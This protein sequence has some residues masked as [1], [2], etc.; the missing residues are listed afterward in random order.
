MKIYAI[1]GLGAD[2]R[3][4]G[5]LSLNKQFIHLDRVK[6][7]KNESIEKCSFR[8]SKEI[9]SSESF[10]IIG[11]SF[12]GL[13]A[14]EISKILKPKLTILISSAANTQEIPIHYRLLGKFKLVE[15]IPEKIFNKPNFFLNYLFG[16]KYRSL[17]SNIIKDTDVQFAK[18]AVS[19][20]LNWQNTTIIENLIKING[21]KDRLIPVN[22]NDIVIKNGSHFMIL[23]KAKEVS[24]ILNKALLNIK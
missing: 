7:L 13:I 6:N 23:D 15:L 8:L 16:I 18:W 24:T 21:D 14:I 19:E 3:A 1:S 12:G 4:Y 22:K 9:D 2:K 20:L 10:I 11:L 5:K 17:L